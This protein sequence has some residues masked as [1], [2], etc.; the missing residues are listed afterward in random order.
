[1]SAAPEVLAFPRDDCPGW[2]TL[3]YYCNAWHFHG[4]GLGHRV[5]HCRKE[6]PYSKTGYV[7]IA[8]ASYSQVILVDGELRVI[9]PF[10]SHAEALITNR[11]TRGGADSRAC[12]SPSEPPINRNKKAARA[13]EMI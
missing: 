8:A 12:R 9:P 6:T 11:L 7:L 3:C 5:A 1:M 2:Q 13:A 4:V 10:L